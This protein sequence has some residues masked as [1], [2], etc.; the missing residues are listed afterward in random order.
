MQMILI[1]LEKNNMMEKSIE[2]AIEF[3]QM[4]KMHT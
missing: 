4:I 1:I 3:V 2:I